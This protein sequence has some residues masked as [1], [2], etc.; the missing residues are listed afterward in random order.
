LRA[1]RIARV[2]A[3]CAVAVAGCASFD[4]PKPWEKGDLARPSF[5]DAEN[6]PVFVRSAE[7]RDRLLQPRDARG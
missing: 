4:P 2:V 6:V 1:D 7:L 5:L 3:A